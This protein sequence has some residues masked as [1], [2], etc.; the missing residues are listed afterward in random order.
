MSHYITWLVGNS[1]D[2]TESHTTI[3]SFFLS[4]EGFYWLTV[5]GKVWWQECT[6]G[7]P[8]LVK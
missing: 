3:S 8:P 6:A 4:L 7:T 5:Q 1:E 2:Q